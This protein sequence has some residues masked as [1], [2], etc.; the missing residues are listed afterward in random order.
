MRRAVALLA[1]AAVAVIGALILG[2]YQ[3]TFGMSV[4][5]GVLFG[6]FEAEA[7]V[8]IARERSAVVAAA[9]ALFSAAGLA[10]AAWISVRHSGRGFP[11]MAWLAMAL[12]AGA[13]VVRARPPISRR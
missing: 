7:V 13:V 1:G 10:W 5:T 8:G 6:L 4:V 11:A 2:E 3:F 12:A 9:G